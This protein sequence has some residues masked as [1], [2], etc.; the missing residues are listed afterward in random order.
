ML[1]IL[2]VMMVLIILMMCKGVD[3]VYGTSSYDGCD[4]YE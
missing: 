3:E 4:D 1:M 2:I